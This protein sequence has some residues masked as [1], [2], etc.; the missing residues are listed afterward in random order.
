M[1]HRIAEAVEVESLTWSTTVIQPNTPYPDEPTEMIPPGVYLFGQD[2]D[3]DPE[4]GPV[5][6]FT[7]AA[8]AGFKAEDIGADRSLAVAEQLCAILAGT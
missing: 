6:T 5:V 7:V 4:D 1:V 2:P 8:V 3:A